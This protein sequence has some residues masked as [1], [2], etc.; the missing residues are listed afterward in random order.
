M[1][2]MISLPNIGIYKS[3][4]EIITGDFYTSLGLGD[5]IIPGICINFAI[6]YDLAS[7]SRYGIYFVSNMLG[8]NNYY[9][10]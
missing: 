1:P 5:M 10:N 4:C 2:I 7:S 3:S 8:N 6:V 9:K